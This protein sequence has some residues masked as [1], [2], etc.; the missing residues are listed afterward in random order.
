MQ[1][2]RDAVLNRGSAR[3]NQRRG[4]TSLYEQNAGEQ[5]GD[6]EN[7]KTHLHGKTS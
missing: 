4:G 2:I 3:R 7:D 6:C 5:D 1:R